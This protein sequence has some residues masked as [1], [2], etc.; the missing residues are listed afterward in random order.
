MAL[1]LATACVVFAGCGDDEPADAGMGP[2]PS[3]TV[4][5][6][7]QDN[8]GEQPTTTPQQDPE[9]L[10]APVGRAAQAACREF[11]PRINRVLKRTDISLYD[12][13]PVYA[14]QQEFAGLIRKVDK[15]VYRAAKASGLTEIEPPDSEDDPLFKPMRGVMRLHKFSDLV[16]RA[17]PYQKTVVTAEV[18]SDAQ[19]QADDRAQALFQQAQNASWTSFLTTIAPACDRLRIFGVG[20]PYQ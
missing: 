20:D 19:L 5:E 11:G 1:A 13:Q 14:A 17:L 15:R 18:N 10:L 7:P 12:P 2:S 3:A 4:P 6:Q 9:A 8:G 16:N